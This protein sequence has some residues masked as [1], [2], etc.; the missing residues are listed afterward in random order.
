MLLFR[1]V[2]GIIVDAND[3]WERM[4]G[5]SR[6]SVVGAPLDALPLWPATRGADRLTRALRRKG[7]V[8][9]YSVQFRRPGADGAEDEEG[10]AILSAVPAV[11]EGESYYLLSCRDVTE[12]RR[13]EE[14]RGQL[15]RLQE[16]GRLVGGIA[17]DFNNLLTVI[18]SYAQ[19]IHASAIE[20]ELV[21]P[22]DAAEIE[23]TAARGRELTRHLLA[24]SRDRRIEPR[25]VD[26]NGA[27]AAVDGMIRPLL[28]ANVVVEQRLSDGLP[29]IMAD[30]VQI[31]Q[32][33]LNLAVN[34]ADAMPDGGLLS[35]VSRFER[36]SADAASEGAVELRPG[37]YV[38][39][40]V[41]DTGHGMDEA[42]RARA[43]EPFFTTKASRSGTGLGLSVV[44]GIVRQAGGAVHLHSTP[45]FGTRVTVLW[46]AARLGAPASD[47]RE[48]GSSRTCVMVV[49]DDERVRRIVRRLLDRAGFDTAEA[50]NGREALQRLTT[51]WQP[52]MGPSVVVA[53]VVMPG[54][55]GRE[56]AEALAERRPDLP[57]ILMSAFGDHQEVAAGL[58]NVPGSVLEKPFDAGALALSIRATLEQWNERATVA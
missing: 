49:E 38:V 40:E 8:R 15:Q 5:L 39:L 7:A 2:D 3:V 24:F 4:M 25:L 54:M 48:E 17:H 26:L 1:E 55:G 27:L 23:R 28:G 30:P 45:G 10:F 41:S 35:I 47:E 33:V 58:P 29:R 12:E 43:F 51:R 50:P 46:P 44:A 11:A 20:G 19:L 32:V 18:G 52:G 9:D 56:L 13:M 21:D 57:V 36:W 42:T 31:D 6:E 22:A 53:D 37:D 16:L 34:A 14:R